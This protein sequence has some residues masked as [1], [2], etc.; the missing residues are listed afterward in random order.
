MGPLLETFYN[1]FKDDREDSPLRR[2]WRRISEEMRQCVQCITQHHQ[3][4]EMYSTEYESSSIS[5]LLD[6]LQSLDEE[7]VTIHL[8]EINARLVQENYDPA[9]GNAEVVSVMYEVR[10]IIFFLLNNL[11]TK[12]FH[13]LLITKQAVLLEDMPLKLFPTS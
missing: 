4:Q 3:A 12:V 2:L 6:V 11:F 1:Y 7:R 9:S 10:G 8:R 5:A 13:E